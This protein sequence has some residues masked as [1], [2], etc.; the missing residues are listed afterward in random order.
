MHSYACAF[1]PCQKTHLCLNASFSCSA[2]ASPRAVRVNPLCRSNLVA[3]IIYIIYI[4]KYSL[5]YPSAI[6]SFQFKCELVWLVWPSAETFSGGKEQS[7][8][9]S[10]IFN[11]FMEK[12]LKWDYLQLK[13]IGPK[14]WSC[15]VA[16]ESH[17]NAFWKPK[18]TLHFPGFLA[19]RVMPGWWCSTISAIYF[20]L[21]L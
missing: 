2:A 15:W 9:K 18:L 20:Y 17:V 5:G 10:C 19:A 16:D 12:H 6:S 11:S 8:C 14:L 1:F 4:Y 7:S 13:L 3:K 21:F